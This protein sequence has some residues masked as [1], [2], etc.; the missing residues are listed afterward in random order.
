MILFK[1]IPLN[2]VDNQV[3]KLKD[4]N[5]KVMQHL[6]KRLPLDLKVV[7]ELKTELSGIVSQSKELTGVLEKISKS[8]DYYYLQ[9]LHEDNE[10]LN[11]PWSMAVDVVSNQSLGNIQQLCLSKCLPGFAKEAATTVQPQIAPPL[12]ILIMISSPEDS[13]Y[14]GRQASGGNRRRRTF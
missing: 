1:Q 14:K 7:E 2:I 4:Q 5:A 8:G 9:L 3:K 11:L 12:K 13:D 10:I 6:E